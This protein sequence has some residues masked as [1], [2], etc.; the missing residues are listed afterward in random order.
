[1]GRPPKANKL[2]RPDKVKKE[3]KKPKTPKKCSEEPSKPA[4]PRSPKK[5]EDVDKE[6]SGDDKEEEAPIVEELLDLHNIRFPACRGAKV[7]RQFY[8][9]SAALDSD[10]EEEESLM[11][12]DILRYVPNKSSVWEIKASDGAVVSRVRLYHYSDDIGGLLPTPRDNP[13]PPLPSTSSK[14]SSKAQKEEGG[15]VDDTWY[16]IFPVETPELVR[17]RWEDEIIWSV[18]EITEPPQPKILALDPNDENVV[19]CVPGK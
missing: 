6:K 9:Y 16:S 11:S 17:G 1:M 13:P 14:A 2:P 12:D 4:K 10:D 15:Q 3:P 8:V 5:E 7:I 19:L 18:E